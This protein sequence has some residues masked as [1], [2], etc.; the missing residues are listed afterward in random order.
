L[1]FAGFGAAVAA[2]R[3]VEARKAANRLAHYR[4][5]AFRPAYARGALRPSRFSA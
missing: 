3:T 1:L 2:R 4:M 5:R